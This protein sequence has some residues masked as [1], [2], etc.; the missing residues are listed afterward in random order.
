MRGWADIQTDRLSCPRIEVL[1]RTYG[2]VIELSSRNSSQGAVQ[3]NDDP[4]TLPNNAGHGSNLFLTV[5]ADLNDDDDTSDR[6]R[7]P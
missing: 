7:Q 3:T 1:G 6:R 4:G 2:A 5:R